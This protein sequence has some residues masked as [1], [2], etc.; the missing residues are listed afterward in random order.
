M[1]ALQVMHVEI[2][3]GCGQISDGIL[4]RGRGGKLL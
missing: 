3:V 1:S 2:G 4:G